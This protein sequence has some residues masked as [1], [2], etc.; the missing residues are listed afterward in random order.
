MPSIRVALVDC[1]CSGVPH[2]S[3]A[4]LVESIAL[5]IGQKGW[6]FEEFLY[7]HLWIPAQHVSGRFLFPFLHPHLYSCTFYCLRG[8]HIDSHELTLKANFLGSPMTALVLSL[9]GLTLE[10]FWAPLKH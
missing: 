5:F 4:L 6:A 3:R 1:M 2:H 8:L 10:D 7:P 9:N